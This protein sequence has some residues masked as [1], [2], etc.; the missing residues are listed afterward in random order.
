MLFERSW[1]R[2]QAWRFSSGQPAASACFLRNVCQISCFCFGRAPWRRQPAAHMTFVHCS[3]SFC[4]RQAADK[5]K[6][7]RGPFCR[8]CCDCDAHQPRTKF[9]GERSE[10]S[11]MRNSLSN[12]LRLSIRTTFRVL[13][14]GATWKGMPDAGKIRWRG[15]VEQFY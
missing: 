10:T 3:N 13:T 2:S 6:R 12:L 8:N 14:N 7:E 11:R 1:C 5:C 4:L 9:R 15:A